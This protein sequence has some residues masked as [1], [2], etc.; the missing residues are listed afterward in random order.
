MSYTLVGGYRRGLQEMGDVDIILSHID[1]AQTQGGFIR[2]LIAS[3][4]TEGWVTH[5]LKIGR[6]ITSEDDKYQHNGHSFDSFEKGLVVWQEQEYS[7]IATKTALDPRS[8]GKKNWNIHRRVDIILAPPASVGTALLGW[9][10]G[11]TFE[12]DLRRW[13]DK[14][15][16]WKFT[17]EAVL[18]RLTG[19][20]VGVDGTWREGMQG[21]EEAERKVFE[22]LGLD[23]V[24]PEMR[25]TG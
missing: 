15:K 24:P 11:T 22:G 23:W 20:R 6:E 14:E 9:T 3:L 17:S 7:D 4:E 1:D 16:E 2:D 13:C 19:R 25:C 18:D 12:R 10:G 5:T 21:M 8:K